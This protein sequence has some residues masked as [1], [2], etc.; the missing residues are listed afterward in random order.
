MEVEER[1]EGFGRGGLDCTGDQPDGEEDE[2]GGA[3]V[4]G[5]DIELGEAQ[6]HI[7]REVELR[8]RVRVGAH[9]R[10]RLDLELESDETKETVVNWT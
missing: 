2:E 1:K 3:K 5:E 4:D 10:R 8:R 7:A 6:R 9:C